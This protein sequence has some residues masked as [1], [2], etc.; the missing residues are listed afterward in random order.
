MAIQGWPQVGLATLGHELTEAERNRVSR[1]LTAL[2][3]PV[4][5]PR[6]SAQELLSSL[7]AFSDDAI[8]T[9]DR[10]GMITSWNRGAERLYGHSAAEAIGRPISILEPPELEGEQHDLTQRVFAG[11]A[12]E[13][14]ETERVRKD[15]SR[16]AVSL[17]ISPVKDRQG[18]T[19]LA[20]VIARDITDRKRYEQRLR[21]LAD[22][23]QLTGLLNRR[24]FEEELK[25][26]LA[27][28]GRHHTRGAVISLDIDNFKQINDAAG[29]AAGDAILIE[30]S[31][32]LAR[33]FRTADITARLGGDEFAVLLTDV[34]PEAARAAAYDLLTAIQ[35]S[36]P[37][38]GG[39][40][41][42][43]RASIGVAAFESDDATSSE[44]IVHADLAMY[45]AKSAGGDRVVLYSPS[46]AQRVRALMRQ[47]WS[48]RIRHA[49]ERDLFVLH[50]QPILD[51]SSGQVSHGELLLR[52]TDERGG[53]IP[54]SAFLPTAER[55]GLIRA[56]D[57]WVVRHAIELVAARNG[58]H[59]APV[60]INLSGDSVAG[61][62]RLLDLIQ[63][64][65]KR[66]GID[67]AKLIFEVTETAAI[68]N[69]PEAT[70]FAA[71]LR[72]LGCSLALDDFGTGFGSFYYLKHLPV[73]YVKLDGEFIHNLPRSAI[74]SHVVR[75]IVGVAR[76]L[77][78]KTVAEEVTDDE[79]VQL[80]R[81]HGVDYAQ[82]FYVG[83]PGPLPDGDG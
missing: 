10:R 62:P 76:G 2:R 27:R 28:A 29:H 67:P 63:R 19:V 81:F 61:D 50:L 4:G 40:A 14:L 37:G 57:R 51:L 35:N 31:H 82:G 43:A 38:F 7:V 68:A 64:E 20:S 21:H 22:H 41:L 55:E 32:V 34:T 71:G 11:S 26:E 73:G 70:N 3:R 45:A 23:D 30:V 12:V 1:S 79:T 78:I 15:G 8:M 77:G 36:R 25:R 5:Q 58:A 52:M 33:R 75:A 74:D 6:G 44:V 66:A 42:K 59:P 83:E 56:V 9:K 39:R 16:V 54:P 69:M 65:V 46:Q 60:G 17:T 18:R 13:Q 24:R 53:L 47:P 49:L 72:R 48:E 80:L